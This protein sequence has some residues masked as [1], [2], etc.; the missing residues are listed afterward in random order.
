MAFPKT[1]LYEGYI[2]SHSDGRRW[3]YR[4][5]KG[6]WKIEQEIDSADYRGD[7]GD[8]G[9]DGATG[10]TGSTGATGATGATGP[11]GSTGSTGSQGPTGSTG[12]T[13]PA[14][15]T[16]Y[17]AGTLDGLD[18]TDF[19]KTSDVDSTLSLIHI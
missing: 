4:A 18:S 12:S 2:R 6:V 1:G 9:D 13:G 15:S 16:S 8:D 5:A 3:R 7:D 19:V 14:G 11:Q 10:A 17:D